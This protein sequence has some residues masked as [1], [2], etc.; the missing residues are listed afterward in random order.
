[1]AEQLDLTEFAP[2]RK[3]A[4]LNRDC[5]IT[6][7]IDGTNAQIAI[8][9]TGGFHIGSRTRWLD[10]EKG[11]DNFGFGMWALAHKDE[12]MGLGVGRHYGEWWGSGIQRRYGLP[13]GEK[14]F[15]LF[16]TSRWGVDTPPPA[17]CGIV[18]I[19]YEGPFNTPAIEFALHELRDKGSQVVP[20]MNPEGLI[21]YHVHAGQYFKV[22]LECDQEPQGRLQA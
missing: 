8:D 22:T 18:P 10:P 17:C 21:I 9:E 20:F 12:L 7:K 3:I 19:L 5:I 16:N 14:R 13:A 4:R 11:I 1:M 15:S 6:E 2:F